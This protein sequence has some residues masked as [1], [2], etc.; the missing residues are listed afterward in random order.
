MMYGI[1]AEGA[2]VSGHVTALIGTHAGGS[3]LPTI[4]VERLE[5]PEAV[6]SCL[7][8]RDSTPAGRTTL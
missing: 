7:V 3:K 5:R 2:A 1:R 8:Q 6:V 4:D